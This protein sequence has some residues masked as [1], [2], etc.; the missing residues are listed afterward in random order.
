MKDYNASSIKIYKDLDA[1]RKRPGMYIGN[2]DDGSGLHRMI[3]EILDN[4]IDETIAG[5]C[6]KINILINEDNYVSIS[7]NGRGI[8][9][10]IHNESKKSAAEIIMTVLHSGAKFDEDTYK[11]SGGLHGVGLSVVNAL[12][13]KMT[14]KIFRSGFAYEQNYIY[15]K[16][17][18]NLKI[19]GHSDKRGTEILFLFDK[20]IFKDCKFNSKILFFRFKE[21]AYLN[22]DIIIK[23]KDT[24]LNLNK[25]VEFKKEGGII[26]FIKDTVDKFQPVNKNILYFSGKN[27]NI[28]VFVSMQWTNLEKENIYCYTNNIRQKDFGTH[29]TGFKI[30]ITKAFK[31]YI[32]SSFFKSRGKIFIHGDDA[33]E[34]LFSVVSIYMSNPKFSSQIKDKLISLEAKHAV[35][36]IVFSTFKEFLYENPDEAKDILSRIILAAKS[37]NAALKAKDIVQYKNDNDNFSFLSKLSDCQEKN[38]EYSE[39]FLVEGDSAGGSAKQARDRK[40]QAILPLK[41]KILNVEKV[42]T[43]KILLNTEIKSIISA[44]KCNINKVDKQKLRYH[45]I[46]LMTDADV[47]GSHIRT[48]LITFFYRYFP[49]LIDDGHIFISKPPLYRCQSNNSYF[50]I[51]NKLEFNKF[52]FKEIFNEL[53]KN[54]DID[55]RFFKKILDYYLNAENILDKLSIQ[56]PKIFFEKL[57]YF[58]N[59]NYFKKKNIKKFIKKY[60]CFLNNESENFYQFILDYENLQENFIKIKTIKYGI[61]SYYSLNMAFFKSSDFY[62]FLKLNLMLSSFYKKIGK[63]LYQGKIYELYDFGI[64]LSDVKNKISSRYLIQRYKGLG[65]MNPDQL[66]STTMNPETRNLQQI[67]V[68]DISSANLM[69]SNLMGDNIDERKKIIE[70]YSKILSDIDV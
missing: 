45:K 1:V 41:G 64:L 33:K 9:T 18:D 65:E 25:N 49:W 60:E 7:D 32:E 35:E 10:D 57:L 2:T 38:P 58:K 47:D 39:L 12:S 4:S 42:N 13:E 6:S 20:E 52:L 66:W 26:E 15:G 30:A 55:S 56:Y 62:F 69:F 63:I 17:V 67:K 21:L 59:L 68:K 3:F 61:I 5:Y 36:H 70:N 19:V 22:P 48:L 16:P 31:H 53:F 27:N 11:L 14:L 34:G 50:Y 23:F 28:N 46:I 37:R 29:Y 44:L 54:F 40:F 51:Q 8:P 24:R 43:K